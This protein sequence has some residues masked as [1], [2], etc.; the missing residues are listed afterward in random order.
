MCMMSKVDF[1]RD[2]YKDGECL[3]FLLSTSSWVLHKTGEKLALFPGKW[4]H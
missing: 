3:N 4:M 2:S 1:D